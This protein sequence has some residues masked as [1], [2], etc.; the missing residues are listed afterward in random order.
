MF[1]STCFYERIKWWWWWWWWWYDD[2][3]RAAW[4][5][6]PTPRQ[7][8]TPWTVHCKSSVNCQWLTCTSH[9]VVTKQVTFAIP[10]AMLLVDRCTSAVHVTS[11]GEQVAEWGLTAALTETCNNHAT[12]KVTRTWY[13]R[14]DK[15]QVGVKCEVHIHGRWARRRQAT[16]LVPGV[17]DR[18]TSLLT[19]I[20]IRQRRWYCVFC[21]YMTS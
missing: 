12:P 18:A 10:S 17:S 14:R 21:V 20:T 8:L 11:D 16:S 5:D 1:L 6:K 19:T 15:L 7:Q 4:V 13:H 3:V 2:I 9:H